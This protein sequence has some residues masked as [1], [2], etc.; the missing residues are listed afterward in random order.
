MAAGSGPVVVAWRRLRRIHGLVFVVPTQA[1]EQQWK[2]QKPSAPRSTTTTAGTARARTH[3]PIHRFRQVLHSRH[4]QGFPSTR[5]FFFKFNPFFHFY[6][7]TKCS[8][9]DSRGWFLGC[10][11]DSYYYYYRFY[12]FNDITFPS[13]SKQPNGRKDCVFDLD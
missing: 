8:V 9:S 11:K 12:Y 5:F 4:L 10:L 3:W 7:K 2:D 13:F 1:F 6:S